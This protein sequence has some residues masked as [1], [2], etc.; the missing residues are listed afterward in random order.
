MPY[1]AD[2]QGIWLAPGWICEV[3]LSFGG[4]MFPRHWLLQN[5]AF[6]LVPT[7]R[8]MRAA[9]ESQPVLERRFEKARRMEDLEK[10]IH[11]AQQAVE[12]TPQDHPDLVDRLSNQGRRFLPVS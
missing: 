7:R 2:N 6:L 3:V 4:T 9:P 1:K 11:K 8:I 10:A 5:L 12:V